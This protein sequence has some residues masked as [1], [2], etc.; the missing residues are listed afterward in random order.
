M[1]SEDVDRLRD[2]GLWGRAEVEAAHHG[3]DLLDAGRR[4]GQPT[5]SRNTRSTGSSI[6]KRIA[7]RAGAR[8]TAPSSI[9]FSRKLGDFSW[10]L[11]LSG[12]TI[13]GMSVARDHDFVLDPAATTSPVPLHY[14]IREQISQ[15][16]ADGE[17]A[18]GDLLPP[19]ED[20][21]A[22]ASVSRTTIRQALAALVHEGLIERKRGKGTWVVEPR[23][24][25]QLTELT[26]FVEDMLSYGL[27]PE[28]QVISTEVVT[29]DIVVAKELRIPEGSE[30]VRIERLRLADRHPI[31]FDVSYLPL[32]I[33]QRVVNED[34]RKRPIFEILETDLGVALDDADYHIRAVAAQK[35]IA[36]HLRVRRGTPLLMI[37]RTTYSSDGTPVDFENLYYRADR[38][39]FSLR[40]KRRAESAH[41]R[42]ASGVDI[43]RRP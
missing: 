25:Q 16:I 8:P 22:Q 4:L 24:D 17:L 29:A 37:E 1:I 35:P 7:S 43:R 14:Q 19:E 9:C 23:I 2:V 28:A 6:W 13:I 38:M 30:A 41:T 39:I 34:L 5:S 42:K 27:E 3:V 12:F 21:A 10:V 26:G 33:G 31:L 32:E 36:T 15:A 11:G 20:L 18:P 40:L